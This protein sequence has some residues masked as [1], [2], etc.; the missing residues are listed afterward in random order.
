MIS[1]FP[2]YI[3]LKEVK[4]TVV[5]VMGTKYRFTSRIISNTDYRHSKGYFVKTGAFTSPSQSED[6]LP[7]RIRS[8]CS[9]PIPLF[10]KSD[11]HRR[12]CSVYGSGEGY[13]RLIKT[14]FNYTLGGSLS[15]PILSNQAL[16]DDWDKLAAYEHKAICLKVPI[17]VIE[18]PSDEDEKNNADKEENDSNDYD[19]VLEMYHD[20]Q[21]VLCEWE[22]ILQDLRVTDL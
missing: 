12:L 17:I 8:A 16:I 6:D 18:E 19:Y 14:L 2:D 11:S 20:N 10:R 15:A 9:V 7:H 21:D 5:M 4:A 22:D 1:T 13:G 3:M